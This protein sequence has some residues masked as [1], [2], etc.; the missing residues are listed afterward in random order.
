MFTA[1]YIFIGLLSLF[2]FTA[3]GVFIYLRTRLREQSGYRPE[4]Y[5]VNRSNKRVVCI[6]DSITEGK[7][8]YG[9]VDFLT[10]LKQCHNIDFINAGNG[11]DLA[12]NILQRLD[13][14]IA[15]QPDFITILIGSYDID[16]TLSKKNEKRY[17]KSN[18]LPQRP[19]QELFEESLIGI[20]QRLISNTNAGIAL[21]SPPLVGDDL[22][23]ESNYWSAA[24]S[25][26]IKRVANENGISYLALNERERELVQ[27]LGYRSRCSYKKSRK[28]I[29]HAI[30]KHYLFGKSWDD[31]SD[32]HGF[33][34]SHDLFHKNSKGGKIIVHLIDRFITRSEDIRNTPSGTISEFQ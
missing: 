3:S 33:L 1:L 29:R 10:Q 2:L 11:K 4:T 9:Y 13:P 25:E 23:E 15:I 5:P 7:K 20:I 19:S 30:V 34:L 6:G 21:I 14:I 8:S 28:L 12:W 17:M 31:I 27:S 22:D 32:E 18:K 24:Y 16:A 26:I